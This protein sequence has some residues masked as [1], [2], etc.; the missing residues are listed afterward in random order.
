MS[1]LNLPRFVFSGLTNWNPNTVNNTSTIYNEVT[2][3]PVPQPGIRWNK[4]V[5]WLMQSNGSTTNPQPNGSWNVFGDQGATFVGA[6]ITSVTLPSG[7]VAADPLLGSA[8]QIAGLLYMDSPNPAPARLVDVEPYGAFTSQIF[9]E[10]VV[11]GNDQLGVQ[12]LGACRMFSRWPDQA[13]N[14]GALPVAGSMG[15][16][17]QTAVRNSDLKWTGLDRSPALAALK[18]AATED[19]NVDVRRAAAQAIL[20]FTR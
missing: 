10:R 15:V 9:Y 12:G 19:D 20:N 2:A 13:R 7:N 17:W 14:L 3:E 4:F 8:V 1:V 11:I 16:I 6:K 18:A 5:D